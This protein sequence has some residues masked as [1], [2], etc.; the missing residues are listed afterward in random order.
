MSVKISPESKIAKDLIEH[1]K[2]ELMNEYLRWRILLYLNKTYFNYVTEWN[3]EFDIM[4]Q[5]IDVFAEK[6]R[7]EE[8]KSAFIL[9]Y[10]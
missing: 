1:F 4:S 10:G 7:N 6:F 8:S 5:T 2:F 9:I 3:V